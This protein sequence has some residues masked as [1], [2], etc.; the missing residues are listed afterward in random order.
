MVSFVQLSRDR[1]DA[2]MSFSVDAELK[3][4]MLNLVILQR[5]WCI[6]HHTKI[7]LGE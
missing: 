3:I 7:C 2:D 1:T 4:D 6:D 5:E